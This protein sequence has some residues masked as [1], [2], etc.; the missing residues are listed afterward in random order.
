MQL[1]QLVDNLASLWDAFGSSQDAAE[2]SLQ[3]V[4]DLE[5]QRAALIEHDMSPE[6]GSDEVSSLQIRP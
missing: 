4:G 6:Q 5:Q 3:V 2:E 1:V